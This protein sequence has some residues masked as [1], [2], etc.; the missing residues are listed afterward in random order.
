MNFFDLFSR[1]RREQ[2]IAIEIDTRG[3]SP[4]SSDLIHLLESRHRLYPGSAAHPGSIGAEIG[5]GK[6]R[7]VELFLKHNYRLF[8]TEEDATERALCERLKDRFP[9]LTVVRGTPENTGLASRSVDF[10]LSERALFAPDLAAVKREF[11]RI[12]K[13]GG[14][15]LV[16]TDNRIY[17]G[18]RQSEEY[19]ALL[20]R[21]CSQFKEK[22][23]PYDIP[24]A[25]ASF[26][27]G[28]EVY[29][30]AFVG[31]HALTLQFF[32]AQTRALSIY[33]PHGN[34]A[35]RKLDA[36]LVRF[37]ERWATNGKLLEPV[38]C[39]VACGRFDL[40]GHLADDLADEIPNEMPDAT[41]DDLYTAH[42]DRDEVFAYG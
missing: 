6:G 40:P 36:D 24:A 29:E 16:I 37:F 23:L 35:R 1:Q 27:S 22:V 39:R 28:G 8:A 20:R 5:A 9:A 2:P 15:V 19:T 30:D 42:E 12:L 34:P 4:Y 10:I 26:F 7:L 41:P 13:P 38:V 21:H 17:S 3:M 18:G 33:P 11:K 32:L 31:A 25:V 14:P